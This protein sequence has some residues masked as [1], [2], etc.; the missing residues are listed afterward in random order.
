M[1]GFLSKIILIALIV[2]GVGGLIYPRR[3]S[4]SQIPKLSQVP[5]IF[6]QTVKHI[7]ASKL[8]QNLS[9]AL[10]NLV[11]HPDKNS[12]VVL[13]VKVTNDSLNKVVDVIYSLPPEQLGQIKTLL[14]APASP[15][16]K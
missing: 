4:L 13:G 15:S 6:S 11:T 10:D 3:G 2:A 9:A 7:D 14:C 12:P 8:S 16:A 5:A 1:F